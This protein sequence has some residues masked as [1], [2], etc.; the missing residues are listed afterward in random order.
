MEV[1]VQVY[2][3][4]S[5]KLIRTTSSI[6]ELSSLI[7]QIEKAE[8]E[9]EKYSVILKAEPRLKRALSLHDDLIAAQ[10][11]ISDLARFIKQIREKED[12][13]V[14]YEQQADKLQREFDKSIPSKCPLCGK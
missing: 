6:R 10:E 11:K 9:V 8:L 13:I 2:E 1:D 14:Y 12:E 5:Q 4:L 7:S 3:Q